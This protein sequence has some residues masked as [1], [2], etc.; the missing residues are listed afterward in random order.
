MRCFTGGGRPTGTPVRAW[1]K[2]RGGLAVI[3]AFA[4]VPM[5]IGAGLAVDYVRLS[6][7]RS[8]LQRS[9]D[10]AALA[11]ARVVAAYP[12]NDG[13]VIADSRRYFWAN[14]RSGLAGSSVGN[15]EPSVAVMEP[16]RSSVN[17][18]ATAVVPVLLVGAV[19]ALLPNN[20]GT[21]S[22]F[23]L[24]ASAT[25]QKYQRGME[26]VLALD[27]TGS[28]ATSD[29]LTNLKRGANDLLDIIYGAGNDQRGALDC[30]RLDANSN[31]A[32]DPSLLVGVVPFVATVNVGPAP[33]RPGAVP[34]IVESARVSAIGWG[35][36]PGGANSWKGCVM[37][38]PAPFE[39][40][41]ADATP[42]AS[43]FEPYAWPST[44]PTV[45]WGGQTYAGPNYWI[46]AGTTEPW[47]AWPV[48]GD[49]FNRQNIGWGA[50][51]H[52]AGPNRG[53]GYP[54]LPLQ[55]SKLIAKQ[56]IAELQVGAANGTTVTLG[57][58]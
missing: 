42:T 26:L 14:F 48:A 54:I 40:G 25:A 27:T 18:Q 6:A 3:G 50:G 51:R 32:I 20:G 12:P 38:R 34:A 11:G 2:R 28:M 7:V 24:R 46:P 45:I 9:V 43:P 49:A 55:P 8:E 4:L 13:A 21:I 19:S 41:Q 35:G 33:A 29:R 31:C 30:S 52:A 47:P 57:F 23:A 53:C 1:R 39:E 36:G 15:A 58:S 10:A 17:V 37:A 22:S 16:E 44:A 56:H 5:I